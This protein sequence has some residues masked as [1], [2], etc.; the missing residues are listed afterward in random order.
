[1]WSGRCPCPPHR[2]AAGHFGGGIRPHHAHSAKTVMWMRSQAMGHHDVAALDDDPIIEVW[3]SRSQRSHSLGA[4]DTKRPG[5]F[6]RRVGFGAGAPAPGLGEEG[7]V[8]TLQM[9]VCPC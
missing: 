7:D 3:P 6:E 9:L 5:R 4:E 8:V 1:M 2:G